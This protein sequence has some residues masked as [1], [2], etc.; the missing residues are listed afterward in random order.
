MLRSDLFQNQLGS[1]HRCESDQAAELD[2]V[3]SNPIPAT[4]EAIHASDHQFV[5]TDASDVGSQSD[6][7]VT[8]I[9]NVGLSRRVAKPRLP[10]R[11]L[12]RS[13]RS[14]KTP[15]RQEYLES[16]KSC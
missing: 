1:G 6:Q 12:A 10:V 8:E 13:L 7:E 5:G 14:L 4:G 2:V 11:P 15:R 9:L 16:C 3:G